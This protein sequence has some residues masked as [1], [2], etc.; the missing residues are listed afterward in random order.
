LESGAPELEIVLSV[1]RTLRDDS[2]GLSPF[3]DDVDELHGIQRSANDDHEVHSWL[4]KVA[5]RA[6][7]FTD[8]SLGAVACDGDSNLA[9]SHDPEPSHT[10]FVPRVEQQ[11]EM[12]SGDAAPGLLS[13][14][15]LSSLSDT[16]SGREAADGARARHYFS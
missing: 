7:R 11:N 6:E 14:L 15:E 5:S 12:R 1:Y 10:R 16:L 2:L 4:E 13:R 9:R 8:E 3:A